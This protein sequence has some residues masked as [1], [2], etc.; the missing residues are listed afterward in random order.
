MDV[1]WHSRVAGTS[2]VSV[3]A[4]RGRFVVVLLV[5]LLLL[6]PPSVVFATNSSDG[7][8][9]IVE[10]NIVKDFGADPTGLVLANPA[11]ERA[12][13][14]AVRH[15][16]SNTTTALTDSVV[17]F[18]P[19]GVFRIRPF[20]LFSRMTLRLDSGAVLDATQDN[21]SYILSS[22]TLGTTN[23]SWPLTKALAT[24]GGGREDGKPLRYE[25]VIW[26]EY[27]TGLRIT[28]S[29]TIRGG[30]PL[31]WTLFQNKKTPW[32]RPHLIEIRHSNNI[33]V[34]SITMEQSPFW[35]LNIQNTSNALVEK[36]RIINPTFVRF[37]ATFGS[38][39]ANIDGVDINS[40][41]NFVLRDSYIDTQDDA[42]AI[43]SGLDRAGLRANRP[44]QN[45]LISN[46]TLKS[47]VGAGVA[48]GSELSGGVSN[49]TVEHCRV[50][51]T[52]RAFRFKTFPG[53]GAVVSNIRIRNITIESLRFNSDSIV[54]FDMFGG[55]RAKTSRFR[56]KDRTTFKDIF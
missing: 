15:Q 13:Q 38:N 18:V 25:A 56:L 47:A 23:R 42:V 43:K 8:S 50:S 33:V 41:V 39:A 5:L 7:N 1:C 36:V 14:A 17:V 49:V 34:D 27:V 10:F 51:D 9:S 24:F 44:S 31:W 35:T 26:A 16:Q 32:T 4:H 20:Q 19:P 53:R 54:Q 2:C 30:G 52:K 37:N 28:G 3:A 22:R 6:V 29:G 11:L 40:C 12:I 46:L 45:I 21:A 55:N 48:I